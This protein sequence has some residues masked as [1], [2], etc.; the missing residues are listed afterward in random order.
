MRP[1][2]ATPAA[3]RALSWSAT[4]GQHPST[5]HDPRGDGGRTL[6]L[7][8]AGGSAEQPAVPQLALA[9]VSCL[10]LPCSSHPQPFSAPPLSGQAGHQH[11]GWLVSL[12]R[13]TRSDSNRRAHAWRM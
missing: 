6:I 11:N 1:P 10:H 9:D 8:E 3:P 2:A 5:H 7:G 4:K 13:A 12:Q